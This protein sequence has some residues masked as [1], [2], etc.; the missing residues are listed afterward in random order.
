M[1]R[2]FSDKRRVNLDGNIYSGGN[3]YEGMIEY[4]STEGMEYM[5]TSSI[6][7]SNN[8]IPP[9]IIQLSFLTPS[10]SSLNLTC[11]VICFLRSERKDKKLT[12]GMKVLNPP[13][14]YMEFIDTLKSG[15]LRKKWE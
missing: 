9:Q 15:D 14:Q 10:G 7:F 6:K 2:M 5:I 8:F 4:V 11:N 1:K 3:T 13:S 12:I